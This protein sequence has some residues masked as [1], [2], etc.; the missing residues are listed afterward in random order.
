[1]KSIRIQG[2][3]PL[4]GTVRIQGSK[5]AA[6][7]MM[8][9]AV[10]HRGTTVLHN[11]PRIAD[12]SFMEKIL[13]HLG[14]RTSWKENSLSLDCS[15]LQNT[16]IPAE[17]AC[18]MRCSII[19]LGALLGRFGRGAIAPPGGCVIGKRP[20]DL[21][22]SALE[23]M[24]VHIEDENEMLKAST[25]GLKGRIICFS[26]QSV[27]A[28]EHG[29]IAA[30][31]AQGTTCL[32]N[33]A[34]EPEIVWL[35]E[36][37]K[38]MGAS[39]T[40]AGTKRICIRGTEK[41]HDSEFT[42]PPDRIVAGTYLCAA[43]ITR[44]RIC[45]ENPPVSELSAFLGIYGKMGGQ[46]DMV[47]GKLIADASRADGPVTRLETE[48]YPGFSTDLQSPVMAV[49]TLARGKSHIRENIFE[50]RFR[51]AQELVRMGAH[52]RLNGRDAYIDGVKRLAGCKVKA[53]ELRGGVA[54]ILA[55]LAAQGETCV[56]NFHLVE[57]GYERIQEDIAA[58]GGR[59]VVE[60]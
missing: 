21:H 23:A 4:N 50:D 40:G 12:V 45:L 56:E 22:L 9:A 20:V 42:I 41:L 55:G 28:T 19:L 39:V 8:A 51:T 52:I 37:L 46:Y 26:R 38:G 7:P 54:L 29:M 47:G 24:G 11:C 17:Y 31:L 48:V 10:L 27:G 33:C 57:R 18:Q 25:S 15:C 34:K 36:F 60:E 43:A 6:L 59:A 2:G 1:M 16:S 35:A 30:V 3:C 14:A 32:E 49:L 53:Q 58:L 5:N 44:G 13:R